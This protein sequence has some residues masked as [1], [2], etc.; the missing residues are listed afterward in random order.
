MFMMKD[1]PAGLA[2]YW[3][4]T[5]ILSVAQQKYLRRGT[6]AKKQPA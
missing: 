5:N 3:T 2:I 1:Y 6:T 4:W